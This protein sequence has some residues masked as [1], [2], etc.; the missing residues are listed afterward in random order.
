M[1]KLITDK[2]IHRTLKALQ[3]GQAILYPTDTVWGIGCDATNRD[4]VANIFRLKKRIESKSLVI[5]VSSL[6]MLRFHV[7]KIPSKAIQLI[8]MSIKPTTIIYEDP[9]EIAPNLTSNDNTVAIRIPNHPFCLNLINKF[10]KPIVS[11]S[12]NISG[13]PTPMSFSEIT[14]PILKGVDYTVNLEQDNKT[15]KSS[16]IIKINGDDLEIIRA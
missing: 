11:T 4:A 10:G 3:N 1:K 6:K 16:T 13:E 9:K 7:E 15:L 8:N 2:I 5:L 12:A 14:R